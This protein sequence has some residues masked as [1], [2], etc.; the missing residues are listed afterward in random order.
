M[1]KH[2]FKPLVFAI[3]LISLFINIQ[4][5]TQDPDPQPEQPVVEPLPDP[6]ADFDSYA[7][8]LTYAHLI[9]LDEDGVDD[10]RIEH[11]EIHKSQW[12]KE[13]TKI[14]SLTPDW[15][16][17]GYVRNDTACAD[18]V[19]SSPWVCLNYSYCNASD[20]GTKFL[21]TTNMI[22]KLDS[23]E[24]NTIDN[25]TSTF[26]SDSVVEYSYNSEE[27]GTINSYDL[28]KY[29]SEKDADYIIFQNA[30]GSRKAIYHGFI[31]IPDSIPPTALIGKHIVSIN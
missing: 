11:V 28:E 16:I 2:L 26:L 30:S 29:S 15:K 1:K 6:Y 31:F 18:T 23:S 24:F 25:L 27:C 8:Y 3:C 13:H 21:D 19:F 14:F 20:S 5:C 9:D 10:I 4:S 12:Q 7:S 22:H 17:L